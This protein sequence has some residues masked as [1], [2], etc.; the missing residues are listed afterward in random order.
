MATGDSGSRLREAYLLSVVLA[1]LVQF[2]P[3]IHALVLHEDSASP[4]GSS[5]QDRQVESGQSGS[6]PCAICTLLL[7]RHSPLPAEPLRGED[8][9][10]APSITPSPFVSTDST[11]CIFADSRGPPAVL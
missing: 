1:L 6:D 4:S 7:N 10:T 11:V 8:L 5:S 3:S 9:L 2:A